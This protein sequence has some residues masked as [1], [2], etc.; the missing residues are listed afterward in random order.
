MG[1]LL[2]ELMKANPNFRE[3][4]DR[5]VAEYHKSVEQER[6]NNM[7]LYDK[8]HVIR[9]Y[10]FEHLDGVGALHPVSKEELC[11]VLEL[12]NDELALLQAHHLN[13]YH[14]K[15]N[16]AKKKHKI[17]GFLGYIDIDKYAARC[18]ET[19]ENLE[20][21]VVDIFYQRVKEDNPISGS[22][23]FAF[24]L[25]VGCNQELLIDY[26]D[27]R[28]KNEQSMIKSDPKH[29]SEVS[30]KLASFFS[31]FISP[32]R[33]DSIVGFQH[34]LNAIKDGK[35]AVRYEVDLCDDLREGNITFEQAA[36]SLRK[37][38]HI[39]YFEY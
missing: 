33:I 11:T 31:C 35:D 22:V 9:S 14:A 4:N 20:K 34:S 18:S 38:L 27:A 28:W 30:T 7:S 6:E 13:N 29:Y 2:E 5:I 12:D 32:D 8:R 37:N 21:K 25:E 3:E 36:D 23:A 17:K 10:H 19:A 39:Y 24:N 26:I 15:A 1:S 16:E